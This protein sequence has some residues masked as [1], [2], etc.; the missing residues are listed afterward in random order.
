MPLVK[1]EILSGKSKEYKKQLLDGIHQALEDALKIESWDRFQRLYELEPD[2]FERGGNKT[3]Q[4]T[5]I[6]IMMFPGRTREQKALLYKRITEELWERLAIRNTDLFIVLQE[7]PNE[8]WGLA[9]KQR[10]L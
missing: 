7:P 1:V 9:G 3:D 6:E 10:E 4:F 5:M 8:N 2:H